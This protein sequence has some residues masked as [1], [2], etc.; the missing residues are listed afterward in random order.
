MQMSFQLLYAFSVFLSLSYFFIIM[1]LLYGGH[2]V[3]FTK[4][5]AIYLS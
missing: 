2:I 1:L 4:V 5:L 3:T